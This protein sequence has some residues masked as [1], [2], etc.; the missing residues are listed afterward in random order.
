MKTEIEKVIEQFNL[1]SD[2]DFKTWMLTNQHNLL[3][4]EKNNFC[5]AF[6]AGERND[7]YARG[8]DNYFFRAEDFYNKYFKK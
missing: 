6:N 8:K 2:A 5:K 4:A 7:F 3:E 1:L